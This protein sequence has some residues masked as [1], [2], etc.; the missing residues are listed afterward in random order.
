MVISHRYVCLPEGTHI[1]C[2]QGSNKNFHFHSIWMRTSSQGHRWHVDSFRGWYPPKSQNTFGVFV[3]WPNSATSNSD[4][5]HRQALKKIWCIRKTELGPVA[6]GT[7]SSMEPA[8]FTT[9]GLTFRI[10]KMVGKGRLG[11]TYHTSS[12]FIL[13]SGTLRR[14]AQMYLGLVTTMVHWKLRIWNDRN[15]RGW[16][17]QTQQYDIFWSSPEAGHGSAD[18]FAFVGNMF[19]FR[20]QHQKGDTSP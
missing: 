19:L 10:P 11:H 16:V 17:A 3:K 8:E 13:R 14:E 18:L 1:W 20:I 4:S 6:Q 15:P 2:G 5:L 12:Y 9:P 7:T